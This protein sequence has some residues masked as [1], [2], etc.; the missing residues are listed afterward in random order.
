MIEKRYYLSACTC[1]C[2]AH[3]NNGENCC[4][5]QDV[6]KDSIITVHHVY[7]ATWIPFIKET[8]S[9]EREE[10]NQYDKYAVCTVKVGEIIGHVPRSIW[11]VSWHG[12]TSCGLY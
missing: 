10:G 12:I 2:A 6:K 11:K 7:K 5:N 8:L 1:T 3:V 4:G 9:L